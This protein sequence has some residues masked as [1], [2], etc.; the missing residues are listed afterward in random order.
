M[1]LVEVVVSDEAVPMPLAAP[2]S[3]SRVR[4]M[5]WSFRIE[6]RADGRLVE[7]DI[8]A[9]KVPS[10]GTF[11]TGVKTFAVGNHSYEVRLYNN[12]EQLTGISNVINI[13]TK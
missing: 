13:Y 5:D 9:P 6:L 11:M 3:A 12:N 10:D 8:R 1:S 4:P 7:G 2:V